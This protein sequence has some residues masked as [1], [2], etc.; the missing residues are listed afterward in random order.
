MHACRLQTEEGEQ[1]GPHRV[2]LGDVWLPG[3]AMSRA[4][5]DTMA[6]RHASCF[7]SLSTAHTYKFV[8]A[9]LAGDVLLTILSWAKATTLCLQSRSQ[10]NMHHQLSV[11]CK[12]YSSCVGTC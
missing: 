10:V 3:L 6:R 2:W 7:V 8:K 11:L 4:M 12:P 1:V 5:G 9:I